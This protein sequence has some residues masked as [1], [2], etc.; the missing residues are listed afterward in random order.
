MLC[1]TFTDTG[2][3]VERF[4]RTN[5][6]FGAGCKYLFSLLFWLVIDNKIQRK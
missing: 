2:F 4:K 5:T 6:S 3:L 1:S